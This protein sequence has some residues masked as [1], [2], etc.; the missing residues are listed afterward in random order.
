VLYIAGRYAGFA[1]PANGIAIMPLTAGGVGSQP[2]SFMELRDA[3]EPVSCELGTETAYLCETPWLDWQR[4]VLDPNAWNAADAG[5]TSDAAT[6]TD[7]STP[8][9]G[10]DAGSA[11]TSSCAA[12]P[13]DDA[14]CAVLLACV[15]LLFGILYRRWKPI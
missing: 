15:G 13:N 11:R 1:D 6:V 4:E 9:S 3:S 7:A 5:V 2:E 12:S 8:R 14:C 10:N